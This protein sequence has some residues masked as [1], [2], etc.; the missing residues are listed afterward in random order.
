MVVVVEEARTISH[1]AL[2]ER[3][4]VHCPDRPYEA[5]IWPAFIKVP[6][7]IKVFLQSLEY[8]TGLTASEGQEGRSPPVTDVPLAGAGRVRARPTDDLVSA[9]QS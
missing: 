5:D 7:P 4:Q 2:S 6:N 3:V 8:A 1:N 9:P